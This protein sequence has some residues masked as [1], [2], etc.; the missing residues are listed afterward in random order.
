[1]KK[2]LLNFYNMIRPKT[3]RELEEEYLSEAV[4]MV[5]LER[6]M[7]ILERP[8]TNPNLSGWV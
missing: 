1:M 8:P 3:R 6:R 4:D 7:N 2:F 5:D